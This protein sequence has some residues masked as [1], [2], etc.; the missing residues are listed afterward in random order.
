[1]KVRFF[2][3]PPVVLLRHRKDCYSLFASDIPLASVV[4]QV[5]D[6]VSRPRKRTGSG[7]DC[8]DGTGVGDWRPV[9]AV[10]EPDS[11]TSDRER[12]TDVVTESWGGMQ[13]SNLRLR[14]GKP[15]LCQLS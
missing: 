2:D 8:R 7:A 15:T 6:V 13:E 5:N 3:E 10:G 1:M 11:A 14:L 12:G 4:A 9:A